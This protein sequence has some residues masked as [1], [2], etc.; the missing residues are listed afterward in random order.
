MEAN[1]LSRNYLRRRDER[2]R[3]MVSA[4]LECRGATQKVRVVDFSATGVRLD[5]IKGLATG[6]PVQILLTP[7]LIVEGQIAWSVW[8]KAGVKFLKPLTAD[9]P[10]HLF[11]LDQARVMERART[12][13]LAS[14]AKD[15]GGN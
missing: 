14:L 3:V 10:A 9:D 12:L 15:R 4:S 13:A 1:I 11:L 2:Q 7:E 6:D 5:G 8:H